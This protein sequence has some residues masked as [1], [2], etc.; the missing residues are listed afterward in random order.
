MIWVFLIDKNGGGQIKYLLHIT[1]NYTNVQKMY[2]YFIKI[3]RI[4]KDYC[5]QDITSLD[6]FTQYQAKERLSYR[7]DTGD[8]EVTFRRIMINNI[9]GMSTIWEKKV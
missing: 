4:T 5:Q 9:P 3:S 2:W 7:H 6:G 1:F 8:M